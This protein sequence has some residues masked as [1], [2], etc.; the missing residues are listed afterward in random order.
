V[1]RSTATIAAIWLAFIAGFLI[2]WLL[3]DRWPR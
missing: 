2:G 1:S 3:R